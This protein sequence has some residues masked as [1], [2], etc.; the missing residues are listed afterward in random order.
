[1][2]LAGAVIV[3]TP[4]DVALADAI[5]AVA[6]FRKVDVPVLGMVENMSFF[7]CPHC[8]G[9][10]EI[11]GHGGGRR[12]AERLQVPF[13]GEIPLE[14]RIREG[15]DAGTPVA[16]TSGSVAEA[17]AALAQRVLAGVARSGS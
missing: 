2:R 11:F 6:M 15:G 4:Q 7:S 5:K 17:F 8:G 1:V 16:E 3:T 14:T 10:S 13:L 9:R 12:T